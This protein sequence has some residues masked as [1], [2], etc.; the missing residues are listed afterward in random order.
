VDF[1]PLVSPVILGVFTHN[2]EIV[3]RD[4]NGIFSYWCRLMLR[5]STDECI[6]KK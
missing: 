2:N 4:K 1:M 6:D 3:S 5:D